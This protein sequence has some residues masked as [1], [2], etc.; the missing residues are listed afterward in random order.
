[1]LIE[2]V[3]MMRLGVSYN[4]P[5][6]LER[7]IWFRW[8]HML[9]RYMNLCYLLVTLLVWSGGAASDLGRHP[10]IPSFVPTAQ[11]VCDRT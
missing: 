8:D 1:M 6:Y 11:R 3:L 9:M 4:V 5:Q 7:V 10:V 2:F